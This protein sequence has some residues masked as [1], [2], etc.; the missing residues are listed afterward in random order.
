VK[1]RAETVLENEPG[2]AGTEGQWRKVKMKRLPPS[3]LFACA[4]HARNGS[5]ASSH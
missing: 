4:V 3:G 5:Y 2:P 1:L